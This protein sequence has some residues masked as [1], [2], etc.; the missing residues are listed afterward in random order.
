MEKPS[1]LPHGSRGGGLR[2][3]TPDENQT[4]L[5]VQPIPAKGHP[6][7]VTVSLILLSPD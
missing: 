1:Q 5:R 6:M 2:V 4:D 7:H 3:D